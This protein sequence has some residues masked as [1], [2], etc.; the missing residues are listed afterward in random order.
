METGATGEVLCPFVHPRRMELD[1]SQS[2]RSTTMMALT[3]NPWVSCLNH[4]L[5][6]YDGRSKCHIML[7]LARTIPG[8]KVALVARC[9]TGRPPQVL[10]DVFPMENGKRQS[11]LLTGTVS[12]DHGKGMTFEVYVWARLSLPTHLLSY[13]CL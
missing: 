5:K 9:H 2:L 8:Q 7:G 12:R 6:T 10:P 11:Q 13:Y 3:L 4:L 1:T